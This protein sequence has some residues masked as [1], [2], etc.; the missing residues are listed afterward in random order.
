M[1]IIVGLGNPGTKY[2][3]TRHN[4][5]RDVVEFLAAAVKAPL[6]FKKR[7]SCYLAECVYE[8]ESLIIGFPDSFMNLSGIPVEKAVRHFGV[9]EARDLLIVLDDVAIPF[10]TFRLRSKGSSGGHNG[11]K[12]VNGA[13][14][15]SDYARLRIGIGPDGS[16]GDAAVP[17]LED[18]VLSKFDRQEKAR[19]PQIVEKGM[20]GCLE[21]LRH[22]VTRAMSSVNAFKI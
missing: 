6:V 10:G 18:Y 9:D 11:L 13:L 17:L 2:R 7:L 22:P 20:L 16:S 3:H 15:T 21:W 1:K 12:S 4:I 14:G 8:G 19:M 5:G